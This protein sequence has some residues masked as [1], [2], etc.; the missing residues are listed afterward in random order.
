VPAKN[1]LCSWPG[2]ARMA[3]PALW[4]CSAHWYALPRDIQ[5]RILAAYRPGQEEDLDLS[6]EYIAAFAAARDWIARKHPPTTG[7]T[8]KATG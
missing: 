8:T 5:N 4:G 2:C 3:R 7:A 1:R 6:D